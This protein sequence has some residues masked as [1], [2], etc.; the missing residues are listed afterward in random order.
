VARALLDG[1]PGAGER[2]IDLL[3]AAM[4]AAGPSAALLIE[5]GVREFQAGRMAPA[6]DDFTSAASLDPAS[7]LARYNLGV[8][9]GSSGRYDEAAAALE[10]ARDLEPG[11]GRTRYQLILALSAARRSDAARQ[12]YQALLALDPAMA[13]DLV[14]IPGL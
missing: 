14:N 1:G 12:E 3:G 13:H 6:I 11:H 7:H 9:L 4:R 8:A 2:G 5:R 10:A